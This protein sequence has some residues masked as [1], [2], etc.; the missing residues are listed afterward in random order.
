MCGLLAFFEMAIYIISEYQRS[1]KS[2]IFS[3]TILS[4]K[5]SLKIF[6]F[7]P[8]FEMLF[9]SKL[10]KQLLKTYLIHS[11]SG[12]KAEVISVFDSNILSLESQVSSGVM[13]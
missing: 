1:L 9:L 4:E 5:N 12:N 7:L 8:F 6:P 10:S 2:D 11:V 3:H 13:R